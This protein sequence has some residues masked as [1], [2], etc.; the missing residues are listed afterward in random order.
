MNEKIAI[1]NSIY[2]YGSTGRIC[3]E[4][5]DSLKSNGYKPLCF[6]GR[7]DKSS[8][9]NFNFSTKSN[10][11]IDALLTRL[12][13]RAGFHSRSKTKTLIDELINYN[14]SLYI[15]HNIHGYYINMD[16]LLKFLAKTKKP[17]IFVFHDCWNITGHCAYFSYVK[18]DKWKTACK[19]CPQLNE[20]PKSIFTDNS[21]KNQ[22]NK[23]KLFSKLENKIIVTPSNWLRGIV[24]ESFLGQTKSITINNGINLDIFYKRTNLP[25]K[26]DKK[27][28]LCVASVWDRRKG[29]ED[30]IR[31][32][33]LIDSDERIVVVGRFTKKYK[34]PENI[35][36][37]SH[38][39][40]VEQLAQLYS[41]SDVFFNPTYEDTYSNVNMEALSCECPVVCYRSG[42]AHEMIDSR[43]VVETGDINQA[44]SVIK[45]IFKDKNE[46]D[47][48]RRSSYSNQIMYDK[49]IKVIR[50]L[51]DSKNIITDHFEI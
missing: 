4:L 40:N 16:Y 20:Y 34:L 15:V 33:S 24:C 17:V 36:H 42:G 12:D 19:N 8:D 23:K 50:K 43:Y 18:C 29:L 31:L 10:L 22:N 45:S 48:S 3:L 28:I 21:Y 32:S 37:I 6:H 13:D 39:N 2:P 44:Y 30:I 9:N 25:S 51:L 11:Y 1:I 47:F 14:P 41:T 38:T 27:T 35:V 49:Y 46:Y 5:V 7:G 26:K